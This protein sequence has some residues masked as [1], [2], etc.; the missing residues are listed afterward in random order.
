MININKMT[1]EE[2]REY[3]THLVDEVDTLRANETV[4]I[5]EIS[6]LNE[7]IYFLSDELNY[8]KDLFMEVVRSKKDV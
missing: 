8:F 5:N 2:L 1:Y 6:R 7:R 3:T 4:N